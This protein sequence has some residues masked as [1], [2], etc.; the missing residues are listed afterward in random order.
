[1]DGNCSSE[2]SYYDDGPVYIYM[3]ILCMRTTWTLDAYFFSM[4]RRNDS[5]ENETREKEKFVSIYLQVKCYEPIY[6]YMYM[7][8]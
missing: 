1:M 8:N 3:Y 4:N 2:S 6:I 7:L 5:D